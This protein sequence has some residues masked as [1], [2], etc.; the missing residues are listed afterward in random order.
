MKVIRVRQVAEKFAVAPSTI[1]RY[2]KELPGFPQP[3]RLGPQST[4][5]VE[6][7]IDAYLSKRVAEARN[8]RA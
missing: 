1:W 6:S 7:E 4:A 3:V 8:A 2:A 5:W